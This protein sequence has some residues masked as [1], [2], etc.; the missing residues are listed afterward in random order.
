MKKICVFC[1]SNYGAKLVYTEV[2]Q[3]LGRLIAE[4]GFTLVYGGGNVGLMG[5]IANSVL[6]HNGKVIGVMPKN[7]VDKEIAHQSLTEL[8]V[9]HSMHERKA[10]MAELSDAFIAL[11]GG[12]GTFEEFFEV[13]TWSQLGIHKKPCG[14]LNVDGFYDSLLKLIEN[15][16]AEKFI[17]KENAELILSDSN[18]D[19]LLHKIKNWNPVFIDKWISK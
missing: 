8:H 19:I 7:L 14:V 15:A 18:P 1:G 11:P 16:V 17:R 12:F 4:K 5:E 13:V 10:L 3:Y 2:A 9:V 6:A